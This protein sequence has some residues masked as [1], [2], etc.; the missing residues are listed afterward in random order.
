MNNPFMQMLQGMAQQ[1]MGNGEQFAQQILQKNPQFAQKIQ[2]QNLQQ[3]AMKELKQRGID[4]NQVMR[5]F[6]RK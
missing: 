3:M 4:P 1:S 5:M 2:G 6:G